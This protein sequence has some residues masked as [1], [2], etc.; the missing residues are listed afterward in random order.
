MEVCELCG[1]TLVKNDTE[2]RTRS[3]F[4]GK[5]HM[6]FEKI[7]KII[8]EFQVCFIVLLLLLLFLGF[9]GKVLLIFFGGG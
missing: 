3:H 8:E 2:E 5:Q 9:I 7:R 6:G 4:S 1:A